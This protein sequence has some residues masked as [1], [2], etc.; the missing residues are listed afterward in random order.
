M[1]C[2]RSIFLVRIE[3]HEIFVLGLILVPHVDLI[4][5]KM[6]G[7]ESRS[8]E[9]L[10]ATRQALEGR[11]YADVVRYQDSISAMTHHDG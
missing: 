1:V 5:F 11:G 3:I 6:T 2:K 8:P 7:F 4:Y 10:W 9:M